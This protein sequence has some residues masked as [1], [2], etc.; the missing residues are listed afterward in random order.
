MPA[1]TLTCSLWHHCCTATASRCPLQ[2]QVRFLHPK[3]WTYFDTL[4]ESCIGMKEWRNR[5]LKTHCSA[6]FCDRQRTGAGPGRR[7]LRVLTGETGAGK[8]I[9]IDALQLVTGAR[10]DTA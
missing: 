10:A 9:L 5:G 7:L 8:S 1:P 2:H 3:G 4:R 6:R